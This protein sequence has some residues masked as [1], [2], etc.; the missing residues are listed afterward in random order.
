MRSWRRFGRIG[1]ALAV[2]AFAAAVAGAAPQGADADPLPVHGPGT[3]ELRE[4][5]RKASAPIVIADENGLPPKAMGD[6]NRVPKI[7]DVKYWIALND[8]TGNYYVK[9]FKLRGMSGKS[10]VWVAVN[11]NFKDGDCRNDGVR[12]VITDAQVAYMIGQFDTNIRP[13]DVDWFGEPAKRTGK[14]AE[15]LKLLPNSFG[16]GSNAYYNK[17]GRDVI[18]V[19]NVR[20]DNYYDLNNAN[21]YSYIAGFFTSAMPYYHDRNVITIDSWDWVHRTGATPLPAPTADPC[22]SAPARP[23]LYE[24]VFAHEYQHLIHA[25]WDPDEVNWV[26]EGMS[27]LAELVTGY[28]SP[29][30]HV[31][32]LGFDS[33][34]NAFLGWLSVLEASYNPI[35]RPSGPENSLTVWEDQGPGEILEDYG[36]AYY[37]M[38]QV[39]GQGYGQAFF[40]QWAHNPLNGIDG[41]NDTLNANGS[42]DTFA[43]LFR[44]MQ[45]SAL[46]DG[47]LDQGASISGAVGADV[48][49]PYTEATIYFSANAASTTGAP[50]WGSDYIDLGS[51]AA[52]GSIVFDGG[53][54]FT[55]PAGPQWTVDAG[56]FKSGYGNDADKSITHAITVGA[57]GSTLTFDH[58]Y[59]LEPTWDFGVVQ[60][61]SSPALGWT[62]LACPGTTSAHDPAAAAN[63]VAELPGYTGSAGSAGAPISVSCAIPASFAGPAYVAFRFMSDA[64]VEDA[65]WFVKN[66]KVDGGDVGT[67][68]SLAGWD[69]QKYLDPAVLNFQ[70]QLVGLNGT[71]SAYGD[72]TAAT[73]VVVIRPTLGAGNTWTATGADLAALAGSGKVVIIITGIPEDEGSGIYSPYSLLVNGIQRADGP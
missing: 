11:L 64:A 65:G 32:Q 71:V 6:E 39:K 42:S 34:I 15:L 1:L 61:S 44:D 37:F 43:S 46:A 41:L 2:T 45:L 36:H 49:N 10:E 20:D 60:V 69:N 3:K 38:T 63:I 48:Q 72:V 30:K 66:V 9:K 29:Q 57:G 55:F 50:P 12:N 67:P 59:G 52:L 25:D 35:P 17:A 56:Y 7:G 18:L 21:S 19:D 22:T 31:N 13:T 27:D 58:Y 53:D 4:E 8:F 47:Y 68:G 33:H 62:T 26:N 28:S 70:L 73:S 14:A 16:S 24:G 51:G 5:L 54:T 40:K 23:F